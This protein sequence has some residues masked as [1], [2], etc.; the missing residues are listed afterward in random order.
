MSKKILVIDDE[1]SIRKSFLLSLEDT[2]CHVE[3]AASGEEG[4][5]KFKK[6]KPALIFLDLKMPGLN[7]VETLREIRKLDRDV[8]V[9]IVTAF[10]REFLDLLD[11]VVKEG[12]RFEVMNKPLGAEQIVKVVQSAFERS[13]K[14]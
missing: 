6:N 9:Y 8:P 1:E 12:L 13:A 4:I 11:A 14:I 7:G 2:A 3:T 10:L 5:E